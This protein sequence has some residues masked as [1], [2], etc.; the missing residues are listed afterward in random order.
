MK[1]LNLELRCLRKAHLLVSVLK[2]QNPTSNTEQQRR[3]LR[4]ISAQLSYYLRTL[5]VRGN[6]SFILMKCFRS[7]MS[8]SLVSE[9]PA[10][11]MKIPCSSSQ[12][13]KQTTSGTCLGNSKLT[14]C[15]HASHVVWQLD[16]CITRGRERSKSFKIKLV[17]VCVCHIP[18]TL[19]TLL[20]KHVSVKLW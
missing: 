15:L 1:T 3:I 6:R 11:C 8:I 18:A 17:C 9:E 19:L 16:F 10:V 13:A 12:D 4:W 7:Q 14:S 2:A 20:H 5:G